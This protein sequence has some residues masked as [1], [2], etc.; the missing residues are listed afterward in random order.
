[1]GSAAPA[2]TFRGVYSTCLFCH[3]D[4]GRNEALES[5]PVGRRLAYDAAKGRLWVVC[6]GCERWNLSPLEE[7]WEAIEQAERRYRDT[8]LRASTS[9]VGLARLRDG[10]E[11]V[12]I[13]SP[14]RPEFAAWRYGDQFG[15]RRRRRLLVGAG[16]TTAV[17]ALV[18]AGPLTG[19]FSFGAVAHLYQLYDTA[20]QARRA[21]RGISVGDGAAGE[22]MRVSLIDAERTRLASDGDAGFAL[23]VPAAPRRWYDV[24]RSAPHWPTTDVRLTGPAALQAASRMLPHLNR[25]GGNV[26]DVR[27]AVELLDSAGGATALFARLARGGG[28]A[29]GGGGRVEFGGLGQRARLALEMAAHEEQERRALDG[30]LRALEAAW[31]AAEE[32]AAIAD[33][34]LLPERVARR[35]A[36][37]KGSAA[38]AASG[39]SSA[40]AGAASSPSSESGAASSS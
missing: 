4:L 18:V 27:E 10:T 6:R 5:F 20:N 31:R 16:A 14:L 36:Q 25:G 19:L 32:I 22:R 30:E 38:G 37:L 9:N 24:W 35:L 26:L 39:R 21:R 1:L 40:R 11:L 15:R 3:G 23:V 33:D 13:G 34:L 17:V 12:R 29:P 28:T 8:R 2:A 7:R